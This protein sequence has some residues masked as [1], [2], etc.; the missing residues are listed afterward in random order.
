MARWCRGF[1]HNSTPRGTRFEA[2]QNF[3]CFSSR[4]WVYFIQSYFTLKHGLWVVLHSFL[5]SYFY[6][7]FDEIHVCKQNFS[8]RSKRISTFLTDCWA[9]LTGIYKHYALVICN[10]GPMPR[11][12]REIEPCFRF[13]IDFALPRKYQGFVSYR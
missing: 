2:Q 12:G 13:F 4:G 7:F 8:G 10:H 5:F 9:T 6:S 3:F 1:V 11:R